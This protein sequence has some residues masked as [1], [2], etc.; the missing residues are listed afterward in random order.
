MTVLTIIVVLRIIST[1]P[2]HEWRMPIPGLA[3]PPAALCN[4]LTCSPIYFW[5]HNGGYVSGDHYQNH[6][7]IKRVLGIDI[8]IGLH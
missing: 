2:C 8:S 5:S 4:F 6:D 1:L 3:N 7:L